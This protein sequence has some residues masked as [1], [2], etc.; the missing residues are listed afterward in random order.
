M[1]ADDFAKLARELNPAGA[2]FNDRLQAAAREFQEL[3]A[4]E[5]E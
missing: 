4:A 1:S 3:Q 5:R 2:A